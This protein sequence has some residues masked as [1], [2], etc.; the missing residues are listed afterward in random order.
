MTDYAKSLIYKLCCKDASITDEY[1]GSTTNKYKRKQL[2]KSCCNNENDKKYNFYVYQFIREHGGFDNFDFIILEEYSCENKTQLLMK[3][4]EWIELQKPTLNCV[5]PFITEEERKEQKK[6]ITLNHSHKNY[7][8]NKD[9][10]KNKFYEKIICECGCE[11]TYHHL[12]RHKKTKK[13]LKNI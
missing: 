5:R 3:E 12:A 11:T 6:I 10:I 2:H 7:N 4:R 8:E 9:A 1:I 13:H